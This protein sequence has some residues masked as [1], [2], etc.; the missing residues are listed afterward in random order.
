MTR[1]I[2]IG[3]GTYTHARNTLGFD[4]GTEEIA[5]VVQESRSNDGFKEDSGK[6]DFFIW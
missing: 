2:K 6:I 4:E 1:I 5:K 3:V